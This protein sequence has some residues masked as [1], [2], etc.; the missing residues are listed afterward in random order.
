MEAESGH[1]TDRS[2]T[3]RADFRN[4]NSARA[5]RASCR[6]SGCNGM[7]SVLLSRARPVEGPIGLAMCGGEEGRCSDAAGLMKLGLQQAAIRVVRSGPRGTIPRHSAT[8][9]GSMM[10][11]SR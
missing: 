2:H 3:A 9:G 5:H 8:R 1:S 10:K 11:S 7:L 4:A 6:A